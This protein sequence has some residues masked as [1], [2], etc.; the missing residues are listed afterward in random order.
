[1]KLFH[2]KMEASR[3]KPAQL[4]SLWSNL[5]LLHL[6]SPS[7]VLCMIT[8]QG[9]IPGN[10][11]FPWPAQRPPSLWS[12]PLSNPGETEDEMVGWHHWLNGHEFEQTPQRQWREAWHAAVHGVA[13]I[14]TR[15]SDWTTTTHSQMCSYSPSLTTCDFASADA[16]AS[17]LP[18]QQASLPTIGQLLYPL[19]LPSVPTTLL[20]RL[21]PRARMMPISRSSGS[22]LIFFLHITQQCWQSFP[23]CL[24]FHL[25][26]HSFSH[27]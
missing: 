23:L 26:G 24:P 15:L 16:V 2:R 27:S 20:T 21:S 11:S 6:F 22:F 25:C 17:P 1:M 13:K 9:H 3:H 14:R 10:S 5:R 12:H 18:Q 19:P 4:P 8:F 7:G